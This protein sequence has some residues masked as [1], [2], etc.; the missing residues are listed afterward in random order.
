MTSFRERYKEP[1]DTVDAAP[2][3]KVTNLGGSDIGHSKLESVYMHVSYC[4][5][6]PREQL[7]Y[8]VQ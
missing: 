3:R 1:T 8:A 6:Y 7:H 5:Q 2:G 4:E